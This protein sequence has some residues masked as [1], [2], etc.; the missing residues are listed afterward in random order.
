MIWQTREETSQK[1]RPIFS[2]QQF[3]PA[4][5]VTEGMSRLFDA[6][7]L[8]GPDKKRGYVVN[9]WH[10]ERC[11]F[12]QSELAPFS[13]RKTAKHT[14]TS[15]HLLVLHRYL[16]GGWK[17]QIGDEA[18]E[19]EVGNIYILDQELP[20]EAIEG[21]ST[22]QVAYVH[23]DLLG[24]DP[25]HHPRLL[26]VDQSS[27]IGRF[28]HAAWDRLFAA[29]WQSDKL[30]SETVIDHFFACIKMALGDHPHR[31]DIRAHARAALYE[32]ICRY[33]EDNLGSPDLGTQSIL[34]KFGVSRASLYRM[35]EPKGGVRN[36]IMDRRTLRAVLDISRHADRRGIV[37]M[38]ADRWGFST[39][40]N[41]NRSIKRLYGNSPRALFKNH[42]II[43]PDTDFVGSFV[44]R[45]AA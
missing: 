21:A 10:T 38:A 24:F 20:L 4:G 23:K 11:Y 30:I 40:P 2:N 37:Q 14:E 26:T 34:A 44:T 17:G 33:I 8:N 16:E 6:H 19:R 3:R 31:A 25:T 36:Y 39:G 41:F 7:P 27:T 45:S 32:Q 12:M 9:A 18:L 35:F 13:I 22:V 1:Q 5:A 43:I 42:E 15:G 28:L 29:L